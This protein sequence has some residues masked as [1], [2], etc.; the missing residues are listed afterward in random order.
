MTVE[1]IRCPHPNA[2]DLALAAVA[3]PGIVESQARA[4]A[5]SN[6]RARY[7]PEALAPVFEL[8][9]VPGAFPAARLDSFAVLPVA[10][11]DFVWASSCPESAHFPE[12]PLESRA[13][14]SA[15]ALTAVFVPM[16]RSLPRTPRMPL[17]PTERSCEI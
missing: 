15:A 5:P 1:V 9:V 12:V 4:Q 13:P 3:L 10:P 2:R 7:P 14:A 16:P 6:H 17:L 8:V 11:L